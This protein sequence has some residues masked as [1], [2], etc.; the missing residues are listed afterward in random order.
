MQ[1]AARDA[2]ELAH[3]M[4]LEDV[5]LADYAA[6]FVP[7]GWGPMEDLSVDPAVGRLMAEMLGSGKPLALVCHGPAALLTTAGSSGSSPFAGYQLTN[8]SNAEERINGLADR[9]KWLLE[10]RLVELGVDYHAGEPFAPHIET[11]RNLCTGQNPASAV[12]LAQAVLGAL[13]R[14]RLTCRTP[15]TSPSSAASMTRAW[16][17][18]SRARSWPA[19]SS[20]T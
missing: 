1:D 10:D 18:K 4:R 8:L 15:P 3:P 12:P 20:S 2:T 13:T 17:P 11:D 5:Q 7:G 6:V 14:K 16:P 9:A 19:T